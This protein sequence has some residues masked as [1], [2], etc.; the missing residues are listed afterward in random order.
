MPSIP[1]YAIPPKPLLQSSAFPQAIFLPQAIRLYTSVAPQPNSSGVA[2][3]SL[4]SDDYFKSKRASL[5]NALT[6]KA[7]RILAKAA[8]M[9]INANLEPAY[10][11]PTSA[12]H[13]FARGKMSLSLV[14][15]P[16]TIP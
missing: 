14:C 2:G 11:A 16:M 3:Q 13:P 8:A 1:L 15:I 7:G 4:I 10:L 5:L 12:Q 9:R 6:C